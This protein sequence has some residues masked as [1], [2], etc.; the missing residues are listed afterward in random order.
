MAWLFRA[1]CTSATP[2]HTWGQGIRACITSKEQD[3]VGAPSHHRPNGHLSNGHLLPLKGQSDLLQLT[4]GGKE[5][6]GR[7]NLLSAPQAKPLSPGPTWDCRTKDSF[8]GQSSCCLNS[9][10]GALSSRSRVLADSGDC[11]RAP[12]SGPRLW[13]AGGAAAWVR[14]RVFPLT[15]AS[16][17]QLECSEHR[18]RNCCPGPRRAPSCSR[19]SWFCLFWGRGQKDGGGGVTCSGCFSGRKLKQM[20]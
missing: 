1:M 16:A 11:G 15:Q 18:G 4:L 9:C 17:V 20:G 19:R 6:C 8:P 3:R 10:T 14:D 13:T 12:G 2:S 5:E 7:R